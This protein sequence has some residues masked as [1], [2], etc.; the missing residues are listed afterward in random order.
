[1]M[2]SVIA[3]NATVVT[4]DL[5]IEILFSYDTPVA[6]Y[7]PE[8]DQHPAGCFRSETRHSITT[9]KHIGQYFKSRGAMPADVRTIPQADIEKAVDAL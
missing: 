4:M 3:P 8:S 7:F 2:V 1:M 6:G 5:G 9:G